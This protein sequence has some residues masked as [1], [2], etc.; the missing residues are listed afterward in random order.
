MDKQSHS[1]PKGWG[2]IVGKDRTP[3]W[4]QEGAESK[5]I[6][7]KSIKMISVCLLTLA[8]NF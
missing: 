8:T 2:K 6:L 4:A 1:V 7:K 3:L 5:I